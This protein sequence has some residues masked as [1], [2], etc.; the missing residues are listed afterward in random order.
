MRLTSASTTAL[1]C[2]SDTVAERE[3]PYPPIDPRR[4]GPT[5]FLRRGLCLLQP[6]HPGA[7]PKRGRDATHG[8]TTS[9]ASLQ[10]MRRLYPRETASA[11]L[12]SLQASAE[13]LRGG[14]TPSRHHRNQ[15]CDSGRSTQRTP[16]F[17]RPR[18]KN[19]PSRQWPPDASHCA[20]PFAAAAGNLSRSATAGCPLSLPGGEEGLVSKGALS[21]TTGAETLQSIVAPRRRCNSQS[22]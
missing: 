13:G 6:L 3:A 14:R 18:G 10:R 8:P 21:L 5:S 9:S 12:L 20:I 7:L 17:C 2:L 19:L 15:G 22:H 16:F 1:A 4:A 11:F